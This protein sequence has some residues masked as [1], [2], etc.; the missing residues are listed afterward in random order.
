VSPVL[1]IDEVDANVVDATHPDHGRF[2]QL[3]PT[4]AGTS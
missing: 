1:T 4:L 3:A 2:L